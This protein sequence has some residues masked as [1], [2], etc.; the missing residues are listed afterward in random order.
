MKWIPRSPRLHVRCHPLCQDVTIQ[1]VSHP[2]SRSLGDTIVTI[3]TT[4]PDTRELTVTAVTLGSVQSPMRLHGARCAPAS[5]MIWRSAASLTVGTWP[6]TG[7]HAAHRGAR[8]IWQHTLMRAPC[9]A[10]SHVV[11]HEHASTQRCNA[12]RSRGARPRSW[13]YALAGFS[14]RGMPNGVARR[15]RIRKSPSVRSAATFIT[16]VN[17]CSTLRS[18][19]LAAILGFFMRSS[20]MTSS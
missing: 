14:A 13:R 8:G 16:G 9:A 19:K 1:G 17:R 10:R 12:S 7:G 4:E 3:A 20:T 6:E 15:P 11:R 5:S 18:L 2:I